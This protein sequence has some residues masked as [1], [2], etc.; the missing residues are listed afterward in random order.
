MLLGFEWQTGK[1]EQSGVKIVADHRL[2][3]SATTFNKA[4]IVHD[5]GNA[6]SPFIDPCLARF[7][8]EDGGDGTL[9][10]SC[11]KTAIVGKEKN[12]G[13]VSQVQPVEGG[14]NPANVFIEAFHHCG[15]GWVILPGISKALVDGHAKRSVSVQSIDFAFSLVFF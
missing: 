5:Q 10:A 1:V 9:A 3:N 8:G 11:G 14:K 12:N 15:I 4:R 6:D 13:V 7:V 2:G